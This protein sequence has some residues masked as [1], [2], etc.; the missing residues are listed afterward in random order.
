MDKPTVTTMLTLA[1]VFFAMI[2]VAPG[3]AQAKPTPKKL[4]TPLTAPTTAPQQAASSW[5]A[6]TDSGKNAQAWEAA[7]PTFQSQVT[8]SR[9]AAA[10]QSVRAPLGKVQKRTLQSGQH[11]T[12][13]PG[14]PTGDY[15]VLT[16]STVF[17]EKNMA[18]ETVTLPR[19]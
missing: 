2:L 13:L 12:N 9:W 3:A 5:L 11:T 8:E 18:T 14:A 7:S 4:K 10:A 17:E 15:A 1:S 19:G 16:Y 6:L